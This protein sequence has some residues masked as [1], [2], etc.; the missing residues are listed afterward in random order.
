MP[1]TSESGRIL[2]LGVDEIFEDLTYSVAYNEVLSRMRDNGMP[3]GILKDAV[4]S[5]ISIMF[6]AAL[7]VYIQKQEQV[8]ERIMSVTAAAILA[9]LSP[10]KKGIKNLLRGKR[11]RKLARFIPFLNGSTQDNIAMANVVAT[12]S[13]SV[14]NSRSA[15]NSTH[16]RISSSLAQVSHIRDNK[17]HELNY[18]KAKV[19][20]INQTLLFKLFTSKFTANDKKLLQQITGSERVD[21]EQINKVASFMFITDDSGNITGLTEQFLMLVNGLGYFKP[22]KGKR[23]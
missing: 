15:A 14:F 20:S 1:A 23:G 12:A 13:G 7:M 5:G 3:E 10:L 17:N 19:D 11:G 4:N 16:S 22:S 6:S 8:L 9:L 18:A 2:K 21:I